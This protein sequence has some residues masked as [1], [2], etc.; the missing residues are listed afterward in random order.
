MRLLRHNSNTIN[1]VYLVLTALFF[2]FSQLTMLA[3]YNGLIKS[4]GFP[5]LVNANATE[6]FLYSQEHLAH[7]QTVIHLLTKV[8]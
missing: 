2:S 5:R 6:S 1:D 4:Q 3:A 7:W 8:I